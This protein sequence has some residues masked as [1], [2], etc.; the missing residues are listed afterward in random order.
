MRVRW[1]SVARSRDRQ[2]LPLSPALMLYAVL[3]LACC[4]CSGQVNDPADLS[5]PGATAGEQRQGPDGGTYVWV[6]PGEFMM[7]SEDGNGDER[8]VHR[9]RIT[10]GLWMSKCE[11]TNAQ[12]RRFCE[13]TG[14]EFPGGSDQGDEH[15][16][17]QVSWEDAGAYC[18][19]FGLRLPTEAEWEYSA[20]GSESPAYPWG[21][22]WDAQLCCWDGSKGPNGQTFPV[23]SFPAG[24]S[25][26]GA[27]DLIGNVWEW[28]ADRYDSAYYS[29][30]PMS[31]PGG[32]EEGVDLVL[33]G[34]GWCDSSDYCRAAGRAAGLPDGPGAADAGFRPVASPR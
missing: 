17:V 27:L 28:C 9:V 15:P 19:H 3:L 26:C 23:G 5:T 24:A 32:P 13:A 7:G 31:D 25:W 34:G 14:R 1:S 33:R 12:Y 18:D 8:P 20:R 2:Q 11:I 4:A 10:K 30:S 22:R 29:S 6:P 21:S 16:V